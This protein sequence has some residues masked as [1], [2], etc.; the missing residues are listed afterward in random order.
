MKFFSA[1]NQRGTVNLSQVWE[2]GTEVNRQE[3]RQ[4]T[5][6]PGLQGDSILSPFLQIAVR[7][8]LTNCR[9]NVF[10]ANGLLFVPI[11]FAKTWGICNLHRNKYRLAL[12]HFTTGK[13]ISQ[14]QLNRLTSPSSI[15]CLYTYTII[16]IIYMIYVRCMFINFCSVKAVH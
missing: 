8:K 10:C 2:Y 4:V 1:A 11:L 16:Y 13:T 15:I 3:L 12:N 5:G 7:N 9:K 14:L 6:T